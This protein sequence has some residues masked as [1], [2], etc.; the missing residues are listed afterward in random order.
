MSVPQATVV[1]DSVSEQWHRI[2]TFQ[3]R[4][5]KAIHGEFMTHR[6]FSRNASSS[7]AVPVAKLLE[8][9][10]SDELRAGPIFWGS[11]K[12]GMQAGEELEADDLWEAR[13]RWTAAAHNA[14]YSAEMLMGLGLHKQIANR[15]LEPFS[16]INVVCT[17]TE[18]DN[19]FGLRLD[20]DAMPE[21]RALAEAMWAARK[22][23][24]PRKLKPGQWHLPYVTDVD[25]SE[26]AYDKADLGLAIKVS[27]ARCAR[28]SY[29]AHETGKHSSVEADLQLYERLRSQGH[30]SPFEH[31]AT[32]DNV[33]EFATD[34][35]QGWQ[36]RW[37]HP[38]EHGNLVGWR[39]YRK[40]MHGEACRPLPE[41]YCT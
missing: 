6:V 12:P 4:Y 1:A 39:Q 24:V 41:E 33:E 30:W 18:Y 17:A 11:N 27:V 2:T 3:L 29:M 15:L 20:K 14:A 7:R 19:F 38:A 16:H 34:F 21:M 23:S 28:V 5:W 37:L 36:E 22:A 10:R 40:M 13:S 32:P 25:A 26:F 35:V 8:E 9:V 31:Q